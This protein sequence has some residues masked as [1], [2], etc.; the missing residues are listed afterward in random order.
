MHTLLFANGIDGNDI[1]M[2][3]GRGC[4]DFISESLERLFIEHSGE[5]QHLQSHTPAHRK[6]LSLVNDAHA[7][8]ADLTQQPKVA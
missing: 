3:Q 5:G 8:A 1:W 4:T 2:I 7:A 6:L